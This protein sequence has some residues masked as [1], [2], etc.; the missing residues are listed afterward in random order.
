[1][2]PQNSHQTQTESCR[3]SSKAPSALLLMTPLSGSR[4]VFTQQNEAICSV[5]TDS[6]LQLETRNKNDPLARTS[7]DYRTIVCG[8]T[9]TERP[10]SFS[11]ERE[12]F[13]RFYSSCLATCK[14]VCI[15][16]QKNKIYAN[17]DLLLYCL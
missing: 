3:A 1:M 17:V 14:E 16:S 8:L 13:L 2:S 4:P 5:L 9:F 7:Q 6:R 12:V 10:H 15:Q 11:G